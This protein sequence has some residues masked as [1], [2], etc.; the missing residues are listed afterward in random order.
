[1]KHLIAQPWF[2]VNSKFIGFH[3][4][5]HDTNKTNKDKITLHIKKFLKI[6]TEQIKT[7]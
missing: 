5:F 3:W 2:T 1:M 7:L 4:N 6:I